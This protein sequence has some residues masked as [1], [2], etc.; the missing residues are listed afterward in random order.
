M[1]FFL[2]VFLNLFARAAN[3][4]YEKTQSI[5]GGGSSRAAQTYGD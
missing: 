3:Y 5:Q 2:F 1:I 4:S